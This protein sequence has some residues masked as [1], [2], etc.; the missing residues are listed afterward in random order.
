M[1]KPPPLRPSP[2]PIPNRSQKFSGVGNGNQKYWLICI[3]IACFSV[4]MIL[5]VSI[6]IFFGSGLGRKIASEIGNRDAVSGTPTKQPNRHAEP[7]TRTNSSTDF[8]SR[9]KETGGEA[10]GRKNDA[11]QN[12]EGQSSRSDS[13]TSRSERAKKKPG[14]SKNKSSSRERENQNSGDEFVPIGSLSGN[15]NFF[16]VES[17]SGPVSFIID[18]SGSM[19]R[20]SRFNKTRKQLI[21]TV[22]SMGPGQSFSVFLYNEKIVAFERGRLIKPSV[23]SKTAFQA[24]IGSVAPTGGTNPIPAFNQAANSSVKTIFFLS[25]GEFGNAEIIKELA[26]QNNLVVHT[27]STSAD[28]STM[29][30]I[31]EACGG[32]FT[33]IK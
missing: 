29:K 10:G 2:P 22:N 23:E 7:R 6:F 33:V 14:F 13:A 25:D 28:S 11:S 5:L 1:I 17:R 24:W 4:L 26:K 30:A 8:P 16:G 9:S 19:E 21:E 12:A 31:A 3:L 27:F 18:R 32:E 15:A 20:Y